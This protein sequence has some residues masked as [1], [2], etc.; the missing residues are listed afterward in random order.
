M[1]S[2]SPYV[3]R[4]RFK[5]RVVPATGLTIARRRRTIR[6]NSVDLPT[7]A[8]PTKTT[9]GSPAAAC[10]TISEDRSANLPRRAISEAQLLEPARIAC[11]SFFNLY[12]KFK[13]NPTSQHLLE[14]Q[15]RGRADRLQL[16]ASRADHHALVGFALDNNQRADF[17]EIAFGFLFE[18]FNLN[19]RGEG[20]LLAHREENL[21]ANNLF[22]QHPF[23]LIGVLVAGHQRRTFRQQRGNDAHQFVKVFAR[24]RAYRH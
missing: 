7:L 8:R 2:R 11:P 16:T 10:A 15:A 17:R 18:I 22:R 12:M 21:F 14:F 4:P 3:A 1:N 6:L 5:S 23:G 19:R 13:K 20:N 24:E 9:T